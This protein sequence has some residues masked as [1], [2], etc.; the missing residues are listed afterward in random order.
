MKR[1]NKFFNK[2]LL[3]LKSDLSLHEKDTLLKLSLKIVCKYFCYMYQRMAVYVYT[4]VHK[5][6]LKSGYHGAM[7]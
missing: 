6:I 5:Y 7:W 1:R 3:K 2:Y 4:Y